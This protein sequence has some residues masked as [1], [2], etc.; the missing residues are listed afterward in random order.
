VTTFDL[1]KRKDFNCPPTNP[2]IEFK[3]KNKKKK[4]TEEEEGSLV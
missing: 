3:K 2:S 4:K 1:T